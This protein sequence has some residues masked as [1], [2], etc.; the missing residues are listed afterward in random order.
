MKK[1]P[2]RTKSQHGYR[3]TAVRMPPDLHAELKE[4]A[5]LNG[6]AMNAEIL[7]RLEQNTMDALMRENAEIKKMLREILDIVRDKL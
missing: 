2:T 4:T 1:P 6:R 3:Q 5:E 7:A